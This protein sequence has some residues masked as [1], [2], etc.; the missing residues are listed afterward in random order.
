MHSDEKKQ[1]APRILTHAEAALLDYLKHGEAR[2]AAGR[3][4]RAL[5]FHMAEATEGNSAHF[6]CWCCMLQLEEYFLDI[7]SKPRKPKKAPGALSTGG[8]FRPPTSRPSPL[9]RG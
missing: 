5:M 9:V 6:E 1:P 3:L 2:E 8:F 4:R 7:A